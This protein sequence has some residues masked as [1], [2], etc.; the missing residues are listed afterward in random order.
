LKDQTLHRRSR[1][2]AQ[3]II[4]IAYLKNESGLDLLGKPL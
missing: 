2:T 3:N 1:T 4:P